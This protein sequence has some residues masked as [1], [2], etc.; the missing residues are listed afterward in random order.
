MSKHSD[1]LPDARYD[2]ENNIQRSN[3]CPGNNLGDFKFHN[4]EV[5]DSE[6]CSLRRALYNAIALYCPVNGK[7][8]YS[9]P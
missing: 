6:K 5:I 9:V 7:F 3:L 1:L 2:I 8:V 4:T